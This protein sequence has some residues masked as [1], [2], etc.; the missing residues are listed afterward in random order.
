MSCI[1]FLVQPHANNGDNTN[2]AI[3]AAVLVQIACTSDAVV[4]NNPAVRVNY[5]KQ[6]VNDG[7][8]DSVVAAA[9]ARR[10]VANCKIMKSSEPI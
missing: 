6:T 1:P 3:T 7:N 5:G 2:D 10:P 4:N 9:L 8:G